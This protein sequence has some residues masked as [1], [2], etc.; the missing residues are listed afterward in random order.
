MKTDNELQRDVM[1]EIRYDPFL[2]SISSSIGVAAQDGV[3]TLSGIVESFIQKHAVEDAA[4]RV[5]GVSFVAVD[6]DVK[7]GVSNKRSDSDIAKHAK[8]ALSHLSMLDTEALDVKVDEGWVTLEGTVRWNYQRTAAEEYVRN[9]EGVRGI[10]NH[11]QLAE[12]P[13]DAKT[14][15]EKINA[16]F[17]R[18]ATLDAANIHVE[19]S[20]TKAVLSGKVRSWVEKRDAENAA[21]ASPGI[22]AVDNQI[23]V[24]SAVDV[25]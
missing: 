13:C 20:G 7:I 18:H 14:I 3:I 16:A 12:E 15:T 9:L 17:H 5:K 23:K 4:K 21:W 22:N 11:I 25:H 6:I 10:S 24:D 1:D 19:I 2:S 8:D